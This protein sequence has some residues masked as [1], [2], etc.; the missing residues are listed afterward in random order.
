[1]WK[2]NFCTNAVSL[3]PLIVVTNLRDNE[4]AT[5]AGFSAILTIPAASRPDPAP[6]YGD[7]FRRAR[8]MGQ[9]VVD[10]RTPLTIPLTA[11]TL[12]AGVTEAEPLFR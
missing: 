2:E 7:P 8:Q 5:G 1:M 11:S 9:D 4:G 3:Q 12:C 6:R 10:H